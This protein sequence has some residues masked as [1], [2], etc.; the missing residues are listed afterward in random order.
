ML[1]VSDQ[2][3]R[4]DGDKRCVGAILRCGQRIGCDRH[5]DGYGLFGVPSAGE[6]FPELFLEHHETAR[7]P[8]RQDGGQ[9]LLLL[10]EE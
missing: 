5:Q 7:I 3:S 6:D 8:A 2:V 10:L 9:T 4:T 1:P